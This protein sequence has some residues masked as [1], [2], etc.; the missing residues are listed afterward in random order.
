VG[1]SEVGQGGKARG[2]GVPSTRIKR[3]LAWQALVLNNRALANNPI[4]VGYGTFPRAGPSG[5]FCQRTDGVTK[6]DLD[7]TARHFRISDPALE[8]F[9]KMS[10]CHR[11]TTNGR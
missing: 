3:L 9:V 5:P 8:Y 10:T 1:S 2:T 7:G 6:W 11:V 4:D